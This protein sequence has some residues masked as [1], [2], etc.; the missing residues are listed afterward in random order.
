LTALKTAAAAAMA[1][2][3]E[4]MAVCMSGEKAGRWVVRARRRLRCGA[5]QRTEQWCGELVI[6]ELVNERVVKA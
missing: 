6:I 5:V 4:R 1:A 2:A 3:P